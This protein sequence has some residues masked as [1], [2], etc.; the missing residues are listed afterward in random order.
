LS[1]KEQSKKMTGD[2]V[3]MSPLMTPYSRVSRRAAVMGFGL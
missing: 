2:M 1:N 3:I